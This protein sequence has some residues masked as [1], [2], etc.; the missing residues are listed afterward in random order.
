MIMNYKF[1]YD[2]DCDILAIYHSP[3]KVKES[4]E[5][6]ENI[7]LDLDKDEK[8]NGIEILDASEFFGS[9]NPEITIEFL[10]R[11]DSARIEQKSFRNQW[12]LLVFLESNGKSFSQPMP[13]LRK[14]EFLSPILSPS[15]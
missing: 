11:L 6:S 4:L 2:E 5:V 7:I 15:N 14:T 10:S 1:D 12:I 8:I 3:R 13:P 9:F